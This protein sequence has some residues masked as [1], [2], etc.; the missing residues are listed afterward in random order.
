MEFNNNFNYEKVNHKY[1]INY[2][3]TN[4]VMVDSLIKKPS[5]IL[6]NEQILK[7]VQADIDNHKYKLY[8]TINNSQINSTELCNFIKKNYI[9]SSNDNVIFDYK[10]DF[11]DYYRTDSL[12]LCFYSTSKLNKLIGLII[13]KKCKLSLL[14]EIFEATETNFLCLKLKY[15]NKSLAPL[16]IS[17]LIK[18][19]I[20]NYSTSIS[21]Y[22]IHSQINSPYY[23]LKNYF[24]RPINLKSLIDSE[25]ITN[26]NNDNYSE[27]KLFENF[28]NY[29]SKQKI[30]YYN[31]SKSNIS[32][33]PD[34]NFIKLI[35]DN[36]NEYKKTFYSI[37]E[38]NTFEQ[39]KQL[40][41]NDA[42]HH[43]IF[44]QL[45][46]NNN[47]K[48]K[49]YICLSETK[50]INKKNNFTYLNGLIYLIFNEDKPDIL[51]ETLSWFIF[52][53]QI[54]CFDLITWLDFF[55][56]NNIKFIQ[57]TGFL[58]YYLFN[59]LMPPLTTHSIGLIT[60]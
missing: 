2:W 59:I 39:I 24:H 50:T 23:G 38:I 32:T 52:N 46:K 19:K 26:I 54:K 36:L 43:F 3:K 41:N 7:K 18:E 20:L 15:R 33:K 30:L 13:A 58:K 9:D 48:I 47:F 40:F 57:G 5:Q 22:T 14:N 6:S 25:F 45:D 10:Y 49:N 35:T 12:V 34:D 17:I 4:P 51:I 44:Y 1:K 55:H 42:F 27:Y 21:T 60:L 29:L 28:T 37:Y 31:S 8:Y 56:I 11:I 53:Y 16:M